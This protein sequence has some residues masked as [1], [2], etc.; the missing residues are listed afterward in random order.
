MK[1]IRFDILTLFPAMFSAYVQ[2]SILKRAQANGLIQIK[3]HNWR[4]LATDKHKRVDDKPYGG[5]AGMLL[6]VEP[7]Y[8]QLKRLKLLDKA[9]RK[10]EG[11]RVILL[12]PQ[13]KRLTQKEAVRLSG[14]DRLVLLAGRYEGFDRRVETFV[15]EKISIGPYVLSGGELP[16][17]VLLE[18]VARQ[19]PGVLGHDEAL[20]DETFT[21]DVAEYPQY[22]RPELFQ[23]ADGKRLRV[24]KILLSGN[25]ANI[26]AWR[27]EQSKP[28]QSRRRHDTMLTP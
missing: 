7:L 14:Y 21:N 23:T 13:G 24:P 2:E 26:E 12:S 3:L 9:K 28:L 25:H 6:M 10:K 19:I 18:A 22:T 11:T 27:R 4:E 1:K 17:M 15:D 5:G 16:A 20:K 8:K